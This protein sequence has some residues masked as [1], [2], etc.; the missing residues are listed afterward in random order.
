ME[1]ITKSVLLDFLKL[2]IDSQT[3]LLLNKQTDY[4]QWEIYT[5]DWSVNDVAETCYLIQLAP[6]VSFR[7]SHA[8]LTKFSTY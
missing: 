5:I 8:Q 1:S 6:Y 7:P 2:S 4:H 3:T